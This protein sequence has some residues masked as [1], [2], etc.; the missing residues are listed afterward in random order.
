MSGDGRI[1][2]AVLAG[3]PQLR[4]R[5]LG[6][7]R[8]LGGGGARPRALRG[9]AGA[10]RARRRLAARGLGAAGAAAGARTRGRWC[11][12]RRRTRRCRTDAGRSTSC[13]RCCTARSARTAPCRDCSRCWAA[14]RRLGRAR[15]GADDGQGRG[16]ARA[17]RRRASRVARHAVFAKP[18]VRRPSRR[19]RWTTLG[20]PCFVKPARLGSSVG[21]SKVRGRERAG[22]RHAAGLRAR[23]EGAGG[24][25]DRR[26]R[27]RVRRAR[28]TPTRWSASAGEIVIAQRLGLVRLRGQVRRGRRWS[29]GTPADLPQAVPRRAARGRPAG[30]RG[31]RV[32][33]HGAHRLLRHAR[34]RVVL[35]EI[36]TIPGFTETSVYAKLFEA[37]GICLPAAARPADRAGAG[38]ARGGA[39]LPLLRRATRSANRSA[40]TFP[41][42][43]TTPT[44]PERRPRG[45]PA[46]RPARRRR[47]ARSRASAARTRS[48]SPRRSRRPRPH[49]LVHQPLDDRN[50]SSPGIGSCCPS[51][52]VRGTSIRR[53]RRPRSERRVSSPASARRRSRG[54]RAKRR[55]R[56]SRSRRSARRRRPAT[57]SSV[58]VGRLLQQLQR[59]GARPGHDLRVVVGRHQRQPRSAASAAASASRSSASGRK[60]ITSAP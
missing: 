30:V 60:K 35:N 37:S 40:P 31:L 23:L 7:V 50:V 19:P 39:D 43:S 25:G 38:A 16:Q 52:I 26:P 2:V 10:D 57:S 33:R 24:G 22:G 41:P 14:V 9:G 59:D 15:L 45:R 1:R 21:I 29:C 11:R 54:C 12:G 34:R 32:R 6:A 49:D 47:W 27:G 28:E 58:E 53:A 55:A 48:A 20:Y 8:R 36:N 4:A 3:G 42:D 46:A 51:A 5:D 44:P 18:R 13:C 56:R 17:A